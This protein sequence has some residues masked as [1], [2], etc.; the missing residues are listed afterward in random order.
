M[1]NEQ[2][3]FSGNNIYLGANTIIVDYPIA[4]AFRLKDRIIVLYD[5][6]AYLEKFG[7]FKNL[8]GLALDGEIAWTA[9]LPT[10][11]SG[12]TYYRISSK[13]PNEG[14]VR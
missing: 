1:R 2:I 12:D 6:D 9:E 4:E 7:Q 14:I 10:T 11:M 5:P 13:K 8:I 3:S